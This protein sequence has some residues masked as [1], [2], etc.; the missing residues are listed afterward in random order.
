VKRTPVCSREPPGV[1]TPEAPFQTS[2]RMPDRMRP[3]TLLLLAQL[4][5]IALR[6]QTPAASPT[7]AAS[8][9][10]TDARWRCELPGGVYLVSLASIASIST[11]EYIV[12]AAARVTEVTVAT[13]SS[14]E[15]RFYYLEPVTTNPAAAVPGAATLQTLQQHV[16]DTMASHSPVEPVWERVVK[17][18]P[19]TTHAHTVEYRLSSKDSLQQL[20]SSLEQA[21]TTNR[22]TNFTTQ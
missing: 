18:Y 21:W 22:G 14:V 11:H 13:N 9:P 16:Q 19:T 1:Q 12:D 7:P 4:F 15:A 10:R 20:Y 5:P 8:T 17:T 3:S 6:A 2:E